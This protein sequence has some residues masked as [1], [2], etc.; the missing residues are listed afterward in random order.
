MIV[1][2]GGTL[3]FPQIPTLNI[4]SKKR[5]I[6]QPLELLEVLEGQT[7]SKRRDNEFTAEIIKHAAIAPDSRMKRLISN[8]QGSLLSALQ[9]CSALTAFGVN[10]SQEPVQVGATL[11]FPPKLAY[12]DNNIAEPR[13]SGTWNLMGGK[14][15]ATGPPGGGKS[16]LYSLVVLRGRSSRSNNFDQD[17]SSFERMFETESRK[18]G[19]PMICVD[20]KRY[21][22]GPPERMR[23][24]LRNSIHMNA[25]IAI[26]V[27]EDDSF[28][29]YSQVKMAGDELQLPT[30][31][32]KLSK[33]RGARPGYATNVLMKINA[34]LGGV[35]WTLA[36]RKIDSDSRETFQSPPNSIGWLFNEPWLVVD[37]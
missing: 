7:C 35:N 18:L 28:G 31:C 36:E 15:L 8:K 26:V 10:I 27:L 22:D 11:L 4:G 13:F 32:V 6:L 14:Q 33:I 1:L 21:G 34:K 16:F 20:S 23:D 17:V 19:L 24:L 37:Y 30:Q 25:M 12:R 3:K 29:A 5:P 2:P 9:S